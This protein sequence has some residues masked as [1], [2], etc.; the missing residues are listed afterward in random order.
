[1][2]S[3]PVWLKIPFILTVFGLIPFFLLSGFNEGTS[4]LLK[5]YC[6]FIVVFMCGVLWGI[7]IPNQG[8]NVNKSKKR[9]ILFILSISFSLVVLVSYVILSK[10]LFFIFSSLVFIFLLVCDFYLF[11]EKRLDYS[12]FKL[13]FIVTSI[14]VL[15]LIISQIIK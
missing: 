5:T 11:K 10:Q 2:N 15:I 9:D 7:S 1:M 6:F 3:N 12:Y 4:N 13:R 14:V 8:A